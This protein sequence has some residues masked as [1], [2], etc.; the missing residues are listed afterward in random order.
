MSSFLAIHVKLAPLTILTPF[1]FPTQRAD[2]FPHGCHFLLPQDT[3][4]FQSQTATFAPHP[5]LQ[6]STAVSHPEVA[7]VQLC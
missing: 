3:L 5:E 2:T 4:C 1:Q 6:H 7:A